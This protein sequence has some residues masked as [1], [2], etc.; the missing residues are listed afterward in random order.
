MAAKIRGLALGTAG[1]ATTG[2]GLPQF[3]C[4]PGYP[5]VP[6]APVLEHCQDPTQIQEKTQKRHNDSAAK[7]DVH[8]RG[9][10]TEADRSFHGPTHVAE[11]N[12][13]PVTGATL[14][15]LATADTGVPLAG[16]VGT[17]IAVRRR[18]SASA[19]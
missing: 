11:E 2:P 13:L 5:P 10:D 8:H 19:K 17:V 16:I 12:G 1:L 14:T 3:T 18:R 15:A 7:A 9:H 4:P 6:G